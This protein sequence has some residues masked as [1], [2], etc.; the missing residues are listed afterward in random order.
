MIR[1]TAS[2]WRVE[3]VTTVEDWVYMIVCADDLDD[4][5]FPRQVALVGAWDLEGEENAQL[6]AAAPRLFEACRAVADSG[7][8]GDLAGA[9]RMCREVLAGFTPTADVQAD[10]PAP[11]RTIGLPCY[12]I[13]IR[14][15]RGYTGQQSGCGTITSDLRAGRDHGSSDGRLDAAIDALE[16][17]ILAH[18][19]AGI[20]V[21]SPAYIEGVE[22]A[23]EAVFQ[24]LV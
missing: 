5:N 14:L 17:L 7:E 23:V 10:E 18:A 4:P 21:Q 16:S 2:P 12:G 15:A 1:H 6:I 8:N 3:G 13:T 24:H 11:G 9:V 20:D 19:C 22:T